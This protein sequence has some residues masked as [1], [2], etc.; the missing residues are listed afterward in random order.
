MGH[1]SAIQIVLCAI[2]TLNETHPSD[3][4]L[5]Y[6]RFIIARYMLTYFVS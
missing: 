1:F 3:I 6:K 4:F 2:T 5:L